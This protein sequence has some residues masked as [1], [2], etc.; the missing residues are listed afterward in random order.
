M[1]SLKIPKVSSETVNRGRRERVAERKKTKG[2]IM[3]TKH[4]TE[5]YKQNIYR[6]KHNDNEKIIII[7]LCGKVS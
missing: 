4:Y 3:I 6:N 1:K 7:Y 2:Q 5:N